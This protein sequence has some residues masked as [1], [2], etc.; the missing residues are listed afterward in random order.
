MAD[1]ELGGV[2]VSVEED[3][4]PALLALAADLRR[5]LQNG[6]FAERTLGLRGSIGLTMPEGQATLRLADGRVS[7]QHGDDRAADLRARANLD[8][9]GPVE[10]ETKGAEEHPELAA[11]LEGL[12]QPPGDAWQQAADRFWSALSA[13]PGAPPALL[14]VEQGSGER[15]LCGEDEA[16]AYEIHGSAPALVG[17]LSGRLPLLDAAAG[18]EVLVRGGFAEISVLSG[19]AFAIRFGED[20]ER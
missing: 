13:M 17:V 19:A 10:V 3:P 5:C 16:R 12:L 18:G 2:A 1:P 15:H 9:P 20:A 7:L 6:S 14:V 4:P 11:W 8:A